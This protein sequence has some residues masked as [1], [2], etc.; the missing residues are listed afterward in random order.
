[1]ATVLP[2][3]VVIDESAAMRSCRAELSR[4]L[5]TLCDQLRAEPMTSAK[6][7]LSVLGMADDIRVRLPLSDMRALAGVQHPAIGGRASYASAFADLLIRVPGDVAALKAQGHRVQRP[8]VFLLT[9]ELPD[10]DLSA[11]EWQLRQQLTD[12][13]ATSAAPEIV[14]CATGDQALRGAAARALATRPEFAFAAATGTPSGSAATAFFATV[15]ENLLASGRLLGSASPRLVITAPPGFTRAPTG[16]VPGPVP[17]PAPAAPG[18]PL[19][20]AAASA[21]RLRRLRRSLPGLS[22]Q[23]QVTRPGPGARPRR[24]TTILA[25]G[26]AVLVAVASFLTVNAVTGASGPATAIAQ[27][28]FRSAL[29]S[30]AVQPVVRYQTTSNGQATDLQVTNSGDAVGT[31]TDSGQT[32]NLLNAA[33]QFYVKPPAS[34][35]SSLGAQQAATWKGKWLTGGIASRLVGWD[36]SLFPEPAVLA[37]QLT[38]ALGKSPVLGSAPDTINGT[39]VLAAHTARGTL[40]VARNAPYR[41]VALTPGGSGSSTTAAVRAGPVLAS[42][43]SAAMAFPEENENGV[44]A[45]VQDATSDAS[46]LSTAINTDISFSSK[47]SAQVNCS[48]GGCETTDTETT[49]VTG[50]SVRSASVNAVMN[51]TF[52][53]QGQPA[54]T[55]S[56]STTLPA[57][58]VGSISCSDPAGGAVYQEVVQAAESSGATSSTIRMQANDEIY[59]TAQVVAAQI[60]NTVAGDM[61]AKAESDANQALQTAAGLAQAELDAAE[62]QAAA[63]EAEKQAQQDGCTALSAYTKGAGSNYRACGNIKQ[64]RARAANVDYQVNVAKIASAAARGSEPVYAEFKS[65]IQKVVNSWD[66]RGITPP[67]VR[68]GKMKGYARG[69]YINKDGI[70]PEQPTG[71][72]RES[73][74]WPKGTAPGE[75]GIKNRGNYRLVFGRRGEV[76]YTDNHYKTVTKIR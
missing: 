6:L 30:L 50:S 61:A 64:A 15:A 25:A 62:A 65:Q 60:V 66:R 13:R 12:R 55:C 3:Y 71:Y 28:P 43:A 46:Q 57:N 4:G 73:D 17:G 14:V 33:G 53:I 74:I 40:Y 63:D 8:V 48:A 38:A 67:G 10:P 34:A 52:T 7:R 2:A 58:G 56:A 31:I 9:G 1:M 27:A 59:A 18:A 70:L 72:Y 32:F 39:P 5:V 24:R 37:R 42:E 44:T 35:L 20:G 47:G 19:A 29:S 16:P 11:R 22:P 36:P 23:G 21:T 75:E 69:V 41:I 26:I 76:Y 54:G 51:A 68:M 45:A 49:S